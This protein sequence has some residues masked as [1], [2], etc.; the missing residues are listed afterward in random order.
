MHYMG[1]FHLKLNKAIFISIF[2]C[3]A[4][5]IVLLVSAYIDETLWMEGDSTG[6][7]EHYG[8]ISIIIGDFFLT[9]ITINTLN[10]CYLI[11]KRLPSRSRSLTVRYFY[12]KIWS[13]LF[14][15]K[16]LFGKFFL[17]CFFIGLLAVL[18]HTYKMYN[19]VHYY[20]HDTFDSALHIFSFYSNG[21]NLFLSWCIVI[22]SFVTSLFIFVYCQTICL[23]SHKK[24]NLIIFQWSHPD[25]AG[26][27]AFFG[28]INAMH[29]SGLLVILIEASLLVHTHNRANLENIATFF[30]IAVLVISISYYSILPLYKIIKSLEISI[31][32][33]I[34]LRGIRK[35]EPNIEDYILIYKA[36]YSPYSKLVK[37]LMILGR[38]A[39]LIPTLY[40]LIPELTM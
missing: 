27:F 36:N 17:P 14:E 11:G 6:L 15:K 32:S 16:L 12:S 33:N 25:G 21:I 28:N 38:F 2:M 5:V 4:E 30:V 7:L 22:P 37:T 10:M 18:N 3:V 35:I 13:N 39:A 40:R 23:K 8:M 31:K 26:G 24:K 20:G 1:I 34:F 29:L 19:P 9:Y